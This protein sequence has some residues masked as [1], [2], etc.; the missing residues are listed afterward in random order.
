M[1]YRLYRKD[2]G[3]WYKTGFSGSR[4]RVIHFGALHL[5]RGIKIMIRKD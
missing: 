2:G 1:K 3:T 4:D 5:H